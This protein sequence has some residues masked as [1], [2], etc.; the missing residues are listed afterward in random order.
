MKTILMQDPKTGNIVSAINP[1]EFIEILDTLDILVRETIVENNM[2]ISYSNFYD[3]NLF[4]FSEGSIARALWFNVLQL[5][6]GNRI[7]K[8]INDFIAETFFKAASACGVIPAEEKADPALLKEIETDVDTPFDVYKAALNIYRDNTEMLY[9]QAIAHITNNFKIGPETMFT[10]FDEGY[11]YNLECF[12]NSN[13]EEIYTHIEDLLENGNKITPTGTIKQM[14]EML[15]E[16]YT[17]SGFYK[18]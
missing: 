14:K 12:V 4:D 10:V 8:V 17:Q 16:L 18:E 9:R 11:W 3:T 15:V 1:L 13:W 6:Y 7:S 5:Y 2:K